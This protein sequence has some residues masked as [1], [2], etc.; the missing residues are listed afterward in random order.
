MIDSTTLSLLRLLAR[1]PQLAQRDVAGLLG[2]SLG[3]ANCCIRALIAKGL[4]KTHTYRKRS[5][6]VAYL[7]QLTPAGMAAKTA[8]TRQFLAQ[9]VRE[10]DA[11]RLEI[12]GLRREST[13]GMEALSSPDPESVKR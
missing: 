3:K 7:Y 13:S 4:V 6:K 2:V 9:K 10:Y 8:L 12:E 11:L 1:S 5:N